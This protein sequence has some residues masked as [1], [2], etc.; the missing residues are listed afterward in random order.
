MPETSAVSSSRKRIENLGLDSTG[1]FGSLHLR[2]SICP[3]FSEWNRWEGH[4]KLAESALLMGK[5][6]GL[7]QQLR[8]YLQYDDRIVLKTVKHLGGQNSNI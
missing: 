4:R 6:N 2:P 7:A 3:A 5:V 8:K 1:W